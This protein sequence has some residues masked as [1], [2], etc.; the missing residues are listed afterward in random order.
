MLEIMCLAV[1]NNKDKFPDCLKMT[2][3]MYTLVGKRSGNLVWNFVLNIARAAFL[4]R[5]Q[6]S[7]TSRFESEVC[8]DT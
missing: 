7:Y 4:T 1:L 5:M 6:E 8:M 3:Y 2:N